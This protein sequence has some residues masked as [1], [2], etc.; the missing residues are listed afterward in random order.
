MKTI[1]QKLLKEFLAYDELTGIFIWI[2]GRRGVK[3]S[4][5]VA[6]YLNNRG[7]IQITLRGKRYYAHRLAWFYKYGEFPKHQIDHI[8]HDKIDNRIINLREVSHQENHKNRPLHK[9][10][11]SGVVGVYWNK[12]CNKWHATIK[13]DKK[14]TH[15]G[16]FINKED[17]V[18]ARKEANIKNGFHKNH[19][20]VK[21]Y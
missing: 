10:N 11:S 21:G 9:N 14:L 20:K 12:E 18:K 3:A 19:G 13:I 7:Y 16:L 1:T 5:S 4:G 6:G 15:L 8:N 17:V 2:V